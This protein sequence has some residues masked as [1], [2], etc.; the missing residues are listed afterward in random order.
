MLKR[1]AQ[2]LILCTTVL[3]FSWPVTAAQEYTYVKVSL[4]YPW[5]MFFIFLALVAIPFLLIILLA[6]R[7]DGGTAAASRHAGPDSIE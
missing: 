2:K 3:A 4:A 5:F 6:W 1:C 7:R